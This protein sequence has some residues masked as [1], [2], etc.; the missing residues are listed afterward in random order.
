MEAT[1]QIAAG[2]ELTE[3]E[4]E[5]LILAA[6]FHDIG[7][8]EGAEAHEERSCKYAKAFLE[9]NNVPLIVKNFITYN[10]SIKRLFVFT[11]SFTFSIILEG[12]LD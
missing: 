2:Y 9:E 4:I 3:Q 5:I 10:F 6:W 11:I 1:R 8:I 12:T 7:Y